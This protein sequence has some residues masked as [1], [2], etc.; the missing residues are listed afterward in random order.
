[1]P[2]TVVSIA[3]SD[4]L[5]NGCRTY[6]QRTCN[7]MRIEGLLFN[8]RMV[9]GIF[10]DLNPETRHFW[11]YPDGPWDPERNTS[12][13]VAAM[14]EWRSHGLLG[15]TIN[16]QGGSP[17]GYSEGDPQPWINSAF[18]E[19]GDLREAYMSRLVQILDAADQLGMVPILGCFYFGQDQ[20]LADEK[21]VLHACDRITNWLIER[22]YANMLIE[23]NNQTDVADLGVPGLDYH[24]DVL[25]PARVPDL[26]RR[27]QG[28]SQG[29]VANPAGRLLVGTSFCGLPPEPV[30]GVS[31]F[32]LL[33]GNNL[34]GS[35]GVRRLVEQCR[36]ST[37]YAGQPIVFNEDDH[38]DF[39]APDNHLVAAI[40]RHASWGFFDYRRKEEVFGSGYQSMPTTWGID[41]DRKRSFFE[42][43]RQISGN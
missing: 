27:V 35:D 25:R 34:Q 28:R 4:F 40:S 42:R 19:T 31:D 11:D 5:I 24:H 30:I 16:L 21:A 2:K 12:E 7:G 1:M 23:I 3:G 37:A 39:N 14:P 26:I 17:H 10:D 20:H 38:T 22:G 15:F 33:H 13:F 6:E 9:Q 8:S 36:M 32:I 18:D 29:R 43:I 41:T